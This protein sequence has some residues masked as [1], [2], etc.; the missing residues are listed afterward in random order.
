MN[1]LKIAQGIRQECGIPGVGP[2]SLANQTGEMKRVVDWMDRAYEDIQSAHTTWEFLRGEFSFQTVAG[3]AEYGVTQHGV[4]DISEW[5]FDT[6]RCYLTVD[7]EQYLEFYL[8]DD[9]RDTW[10][11][12]TQRARSGRPSCFTIKPNNVIMFDC[13]PD[14]AYTIVGDYYKLPVARGSES[15]SPVFPEQYHVGVIWRALMY[16]GT[17]AAEPDKYGVGS[18]EYQRV[19]RRMASTQLPMFTAGRPLA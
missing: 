1:F 4:N 18:D 14:A 19:M 17:Y 8:Y 12:G 16:F 15:D 3:T 10:K 6:F 11:I 2:T 5:A 7:D 13:V 9:F